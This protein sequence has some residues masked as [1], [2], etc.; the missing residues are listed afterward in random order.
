MKIPRSLE[1]ISDVGR[2]WG[3]LIAKF[4]LQQFD[5]SEFASVTPA[6]GP[7]HQKSFYEDI[8]KSRSRIRS[9]WHT[10][11]PRNVQDMVDDQFEWFGNMF[12]VF[13]VQIRWRATTSS[14]HSI[15][16]ESATSGR[17]ESL[18]TCQVISLVVWWLCSR[19]AHLAWVQRSLSTF[20][21]G[22]IFTALN[23]KYFLYI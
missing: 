19:V 5:S 7:F 21:D 13:L 3:F 17:A 18:R 16:E 10:S 11:L 14:K 8:T 22:R 4:N 23:P 12:I 1:V 15:S 20:H 9:D 2:H 6:F